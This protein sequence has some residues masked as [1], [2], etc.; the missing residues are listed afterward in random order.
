MAQASAMVFHPTVKLSYIFDCGIFC[1]LDEKIRKLDEQLVKHRDT[2]KKTRAGPA[3][4]AA[5]RRALGVRIFGP[6][7]RSV[8][9]DFRS[10]L[11]LNSAQ[12]MTCQ[13]IW[14]PYKM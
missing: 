8:A 3:Q 7:M 5:K 13:L 9:D 6:M 12:R 11:E 14:L 2:I 10:C 1:R 4:E